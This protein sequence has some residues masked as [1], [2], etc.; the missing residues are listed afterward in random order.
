MERIGT[1]R[2]MQAYM[3]TYNI[4]SVNLPV[5]SASVSEKSDNL[6]VNSENA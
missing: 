5:E 2:R 1:R 3:H 4:Q 6:N